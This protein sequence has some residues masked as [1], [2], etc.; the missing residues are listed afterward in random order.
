MSSRF[1]SSVF[2]SA[3]LAALPA[4]GRADV[5][6]DLRPF[7][8]AHCIECH[9]PEKEKGDVR[10]DGVIDEETL[11]SVFDVIDVRDMPPKKATSH[12]SDDER[13]Q[14][15]DLLGA[16]LAA[17]AERPLALRRL[18]RA[19]YENTIHDLL[20][21]DT[22]LAE[23]LPEDGSTQGF[24]N[25]AGGGL[26]ISSILMERYLEAADV[27][28]ES[29][30]R[31]IEPLPAETRRAATMESKENIDS[32]KKKKGGTIQVA[33]SFVKFSPGWP[34]VRIDDSHPI[35][36]GV[37]RCRVAVWPLDPGENRTLSVAIYTGSLFGPEKKRFEGM[38]DV[39]GTPGD[40]RIIEFNARFKAGEAIHIVP[41]IYPEHVTWRD[42]DFEKQPGVAVKWV[43]TYGPLDQ[44]FPSLAQR[45]LFGESPTIHLQEAGTVYLRHRKNV[46]SHEVISDQPRED[47]ARIIRELAPRAFRRPVEDATIQ[48]YVDLTLSRLDE[49]RTFEQAVRAGVT[50][51]LCAPQFLLLNREADVDDYTLASRL[52][53]FLWSSMPD[54]ELLKLAETG[55]LSDPFVRRAQVDRLLADAKAERFIENFTGQW[56]DLREIE[57]TTPDAKLYPEFDPLLQES[58]L[59]ETRGF[60]RHLLTNNLSITNFIDSDFAI[61][62]QRLADHYGVPGVTGHEHF[63]VVNLP[64][65]SVRGGVLAQASVMKV[66]ANGTTTSPVLRGVW[67][68]NNI[69][70]KPSPPPPPGV[71]AVEPDIRGATTIR[72][73]LSRHSEDASCARC[74]A[75]IDPP[76][77]ALE[78]FDPIGGFRDR[79]RSLG[80]G[81]APEGVR[82]ARYKLGPGVE[83]DGEMPDGTAFADFTD[84]RRQLTERPDP[85]IHAFA[86]KMLVYATGRPITSADGP[87][88]DALVARAQKDGLGLRDLIKAVVENELFTLP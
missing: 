45:Q 29:T 79:Y 32:V 73:Q 70:G 30:I 35:E 38:F 4:I 3:L 75:R 84:F 87:A 20:G 60:F 71:P 39:T 76:G 82:K 37:Y 11:A 59:G 58:M 47:A 33:D 81:D 63:Q 2:A 68:L 66:T 77:F 10:L 44:E 8:K 86:E 9:G 83:T 6:E 40:P 55:K 27:A 80:E 85:F 53:Y 25:V 21:I 1:L 31:R 41:W 49:G 13:Q 7:L 88:V 72:D 65:D 46:A 18:N 54:G 15:L 34:P 67:V 12:P 23:L 78:C 26:S 43:E 50:A 69:L 17:S 62:N 57:F 48:P 5:V 14:T 42:K 51:V 19:E 28:F 24:D 56:L 22:P 36:D 64:D 61:L 74:H 52:S 16:H